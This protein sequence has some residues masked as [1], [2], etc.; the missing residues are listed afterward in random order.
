MKRILPLLLLALMSGCSTAAGFVADKGNKY[1]ALRPDAADAAIAD[2]NAALA[3]A[4]AKFEVNGLT[5]LAE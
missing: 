2:I 4:G 5:C 1:C 3:D